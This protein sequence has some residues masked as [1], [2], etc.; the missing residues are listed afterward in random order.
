MRAS[1]RVRSALAVATTCVALSACGDGDGGAPTSP[2]AP[3][4]NAGVASGL[5]AERFKALDAL[6]VAILPSDEISGDEP[7]EQI[8]AASRSAVA[9][10]D[11]LDADDPLLGALRRPCPKVA[12]LARQFDEIEGCETSPVNRCLG[13][14]GVTQVTLA[15]IKRLSRG[16]DRAIAQAELTPGCR[17]ALV[18]PALAYE[19]F[20]GFAQALQ[21]L[22]GGYERGSAADV[23]R[24]NRAIAQTGVKA[25]ALP[26]ARQSLERFRGAC[27]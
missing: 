17:E 6:Y 15:D 14:V 19:A 1:S 27:A 5:G 16:A 12:R 2:A 23:E 13:V 26:S 4:A 25:E 18:T 21:L 24:G 10:C 22:E 8:E 7:F 11:A 3:P 20:A 9:A